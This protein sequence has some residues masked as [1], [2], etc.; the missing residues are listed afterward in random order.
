[1]IRNKSIQIESNRWLNKIILEQNFKPKYYIT[2]K[3]IE[4]KSTRI[5][6]TEKLFK[7]FKNLLLCRIYRVTAK[8]RLPIDRI[9]MLGFHELGESQTH[10]HTH[11]LIEDIP[12]YPTIESIMTLLELVKM[13][14]PGMQK[15]INEAHINKFH[16]N[17]KSYS[18]K[19][20]NRD[21]LSLDIYNSDL[22]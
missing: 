6:Q 2:I 22:I 8:S 19:Q 4:S 16:R 7:H 13:K 1:M 14:H 18:L 20:T 11:I 15:G 17:Q 5:E 10:F 12:G 9:R 21:Y 3:Y